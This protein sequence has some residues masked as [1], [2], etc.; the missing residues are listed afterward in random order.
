MPSTVCVVGVGCQLSQ[1]ANPHRHCLPAGGAQAADVHPPLSVHE[2]LGK[3]DQHCRDV[4]DAT[5][6]AGQHIAAINSSNNKYDSNNTLLMLTAFKLM[7]HIR[8]S[9]FVGDL[10]RRQEQFL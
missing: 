4:G 1:E 2:G 5:A 8:D 3:E 7:Y 9:V 6:E 10:Q